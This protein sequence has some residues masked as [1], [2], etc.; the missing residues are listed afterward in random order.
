MSRAYDASRR[1]EQAQQTRRRILDAAVV[2]HRQGITAYEP[3]AAAAG[4]STA[5][6]RKHFPNKEAIFQGCTGHFFATFHPPDLEAAAALSDPR[7]RL[8]LVAR[9][10]CR[11]HEETHDLIWAGYAHAAESPALTGAI[12][13]LVGLVHAAADVAVDA[14][15]LDDVARQATCLRLRA[16]LDTL[17]YRAFRVH[18]GLDVEATQHELTTLLGSAAGVPPI[19]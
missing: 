1:T 14:L 10:M 9:E 17:T 7:A 13:A 11:V 4:V 8:A 6:V 3:L 19:D 16:L 2:L 12:E 15:A 5:T 18:A